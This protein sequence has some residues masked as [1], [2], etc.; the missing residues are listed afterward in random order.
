MHGLQTESEDEMI[1]RN[2][3]WFFAWWPFV[4]RRETPEKSRSKHQPCVHAY[5]QKL[6]V[7]A[8]EWSGSKLESMQVAFH[9]GPLTQESQ[10]S[11]VQNKIA[12][13]RD[14]HNDKYPYAMACCM[15]LAGLKGQSSFQHDLFLS[16]L[17]LC[18]KLL[19]LRRPRLCK[20]RSQQPKLEQNQQ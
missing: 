6:K 20:C 15:F 16:R 14:V 2:V 13:A 4:V 12:N 18:S 11:L 3:T 5:R 17:V 8:V 10:Y 1:T 7:R 19:P 9:C